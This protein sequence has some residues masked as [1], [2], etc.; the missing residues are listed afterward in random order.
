[1]KRLAYNTVA[2]L[3]QQIIT[4]ICGFIL[5]RL[6]L[7]FF[8]SEANG[9]VSSITQFLGL[10]SLLDL[11]MTAVVS[12]SLYKPLAQNNQQSISQIMRFSRNFFRKLAIIFAAYCVILVFVY[13]IIVES[14]FDFYFVALLI[15]IMSINTFSEYYFGLVNK[16]LL[17]ADQRAYVQ[18]TINVFTSV[19]NLLVNII[20]V[21][22]GVGL[23]AIKLMTTFIFLLRPMLMGYYV[24]KKYN[25]NWKIKI[26]GNPI[27]QRWNGVAQHVAFVILNNTDT[28]ILSIFSTLGNVS[29][30]AVYNLVQQGIKQLISSINL[31]IT[32]IMGSL[33]AKNE[34]R[35][36]ISFF[37]K[38][39]W[40]YH[41]VVTFS[42]TIVGILILPFVMVFTKGINDVDYYAPLFAVLITMS[43][44][45]Y[46]LRIPYNMMVLAGG[47][48]K[49]TQSSCII[50]AA[51]NIIISFISVFKFGLVGVA[52]GTLC[53]ML[54]RTVY[55]VFYLSD[56][57]IKRSAKYFIKHMFINTISVVIM[58]LSTI[59]INI[60]EINYFS[61]ITMACKVTGICIL[62][63][64]IINMVFYFKELKNA[65]LSI[66]R[67]IINNNEGRKR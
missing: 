11:G 58:V 56:N 43:S 66:R 24:Y 46:C 38:I 61:W 22:M 65:I 34:E 57:I 64:I 10:I 54:Y 5:P 31:G 53:A 1:M 29:I 4:I 45:A 44:A 41:T 23:H 28:V 67:I 51:I 47:H 59:N 40:A 13:P 49:E 63:I 2:S 18:L 19:L 12:S 42:F 15:F 14:I 37:G 52:V 62:D 8:G 21:R 39:E 3:V 55:L 50:E 33:L 6:Y 32:P 16:I 30:Y 36:L 26:V 48:Y 7:E 25:I 27:P 60:E 9:L 20:L 35:K 17:N